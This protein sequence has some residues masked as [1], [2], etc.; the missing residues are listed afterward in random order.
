MQRQEGALMPEET[1]DPE[2]LV[3]EVTFAV[4]GDGRTIEARIVPYNAPTEVVD[5]PRNGGTGIPYVERWLPG[6]FSRQQ[7][8]ADKVL[9]N[10]EHEQ[11][12]RGVVGHGVALREAPDALYG[13]FRVHPGTDGDKALHMV[14][15]GVLTGLSIEAM[16]VKTMRSKEGFV[17][18]VKAKLDNVALVRRGAYADALV[19]AVREAPPDDDPPPP[20]PVNPEVDETLK[21]LGYTPIPKTISRRPWNPSRAR[22]TDEQWEASLVGGMPVLEPDG[23][24]SPQ[25]VKRAAQQIGT[26]ALVERGDVARKL[27]R[28][29]RKAGLEVPTNL[30]RHA[31]I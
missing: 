19:L 2:R 18:R 30:R 20:E 15:E 24:V 4:E 22:F 23:E 21:R 28:L 5:H 13:T 14:N 17:D 12:L 7:K 8:A 1:H 9:L 31:S 10:F 26:V 16:P 25:A 29:H 27:I 3:R 11:G 6:A